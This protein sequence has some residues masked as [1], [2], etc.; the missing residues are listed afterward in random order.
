[1]T[2]RGSAPVI[3]FLFTDLIGSTQ[4]TDS[5]GNEGAQEILRMH[6][7]LVRAEV[8]RHGGSEVKTMGDA[9]KIAFQST[10]SALEC[11]VAIQRSV[12]QHN[13]E[14]PT[15]EF[16]VRMGL[17]A[18]EAIHEEADFFGAAVIVA[19]KIADLA[20]GGEIL[21]S[22]AVKRLSHGMIGI[23]YEFKGEFQLKGLREPYRIYQVISGPAGQPAVPALHG[24]RFAGRDKELDELKECLED[25][26]SGA[27]L[28]VL[29]AGERGIGKSRL[30]EELARYATSRGF[31]VFRGRC[32]ETKG[33]P[34]YAP[35]VEILLDY[36]QS[37]PEGVLL[38]DLGDDASEMAKLV[39]ELT[40]PV[41]IEREG[42]PL[43]PEQEGYQLL[44][45]V[46][47]WLE[48]LAHSRPV[49]LFIEDLQWADSASCLLLQHL[50]PSLMTAPV[51]I[52][53]T[54]SEEDLQPLDHLS[55]ALAE[56]GRLQRYRHITLTGL[57]VSA[58][59]EILSAMGSGEPPTE[60]VETIQEQTGGNPY[61]LTELVNHLDAEGK[62]FGPDGEWRPALFEN[63]WDIPPNVRE[64]VQRRLSNL[65]AATRKVLTAAAAVSNDFSY[66]M[67]ATST[68][69]SSEGLLDG[70]EEG[71]RRGIIEE[72][73][74][75]ADRFRFTR[76]VT[77]QILLYAADKNR[78]P[79]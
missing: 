62:L 7:A 73:E 41:R 33:A 77:R 26:M 25:V 4:L 30:A 27:G 64:V 58:L 28:F 43:P 53:G 76:Q 32:S 2:S 16:M 72:A 45:A 75:G 11:A 56:F 71:I 15:R 10:T 5:L 1:M 79:R 22:E 68:N 19:S 42:Q 20:D 48:N 63:E 13:E 34:S 40:R 50:A 52:L 39:S 47:G 66:D 24:P 61:F 38:D 21:T 36:N 57:T 46:R 60:L 74:G 54:C 44:E 70:L 29:L 55:R 8:K 3:T 12:A 31:R 67:L 23:G 18:G 6:N 69:I 9:F 59:R 78:S 65:S 14:H 35:F 51:L 17:N 49:L 37:R